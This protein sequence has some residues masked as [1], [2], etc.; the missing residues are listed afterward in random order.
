MSGVVKIARDCTYVQ[1]EM[2]K[3]K[4]EEWG[5]RRTDRCPLTGSLIRLSCL[6]FF[7][8]TTRISGSAVII[9]M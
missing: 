9:L 8:R 5:S 6:F 2:K 3:R 4:G 1:R 7:T